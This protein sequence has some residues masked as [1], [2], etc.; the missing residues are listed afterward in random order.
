[1]LYWYRPFIY[2]LWIL[3]R[4]AAAGNVCGADRYFFGDEGGSCIYPVRDT[5]DRSNGHMGFR[6]HRLAAGGHS[7]DRLVLDE[8]TGVAC[9]QR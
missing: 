5:L 4:G 6:S 9:D 1:M 3:P 7:R 8:K 2:A